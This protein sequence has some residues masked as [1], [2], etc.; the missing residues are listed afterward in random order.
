MYLCFVLFILFFCSSTN[1]L[2]DL[3]S[4]PPSYLSFGLHFWC[5][6]V[7]LVFHSWISAPPTPPR[8][9]WFLLLRH[10][11]TD[12]KLWLGQLSFG[13]QSFLPE[14]HFP[15]LGS[16]DM[17]SNYCKKNN[18]VSVKAEFQLDQ[19]GSFRVGIFCCSTHS[20]NGKLDFG[21][22]QNWAHESRS[23]FLCPRV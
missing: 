9:R 20:S 15:W 22:V 12:L 8:S 13:A 10:C 14:A 19:N 6:P 4:L 16:A 2:L 3:I 5:R 1:F 21:Q 7:R 17:L 23:P 18:N 11:V